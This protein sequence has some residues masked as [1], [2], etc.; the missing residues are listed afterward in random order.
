M[1][2]DVDTPAPVL[3]RKDEVPPAVRALCEK[4]HAVSK[5]VPVL[6]FVP[7]GDRSRLYPVVIIG[8]SA[9][10]RARDVDAWLDGQS[11][12]PP[13]D[14]LRLQYDLRLEAIHE[15][16]DYLPVIAFLPGEGGMHP[17]SLVPE[18]VDPGMRDCYLA[19]RQARQDGVGRTPI[20]VPPQSRRRPIAPS[21][22]NEADSP[23]IGPTGE[24]TH[25]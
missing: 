9:A 4:V 3:K 8:E 5:A 12:D 18:D 2:N 21:G 6:V 23:R 19:V 16:A 14:A 15:A 7:N 20:D 13:S 1:T 17:V 24:N 11:L 10:A 25:E 22:A